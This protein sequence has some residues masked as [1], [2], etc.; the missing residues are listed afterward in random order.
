MSLSPGIETPEQVQERIADL[1]RKLRARTD[2]NGDP[3]PRFKDNVA[4]IRGEIE[5]LQGMG[6]E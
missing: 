1:Q 4:A 3:L 5:R 6:D 2:R